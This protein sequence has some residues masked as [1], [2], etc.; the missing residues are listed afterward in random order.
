MFQFSCVFH[1]SFSLRGVQTWRVQQQYVK[2]WHMKG[3]AVR[4]TVKYGTGCTLNYHLVQ[5]MLQAIC[6]LK[7]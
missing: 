1:C 6:N 7:Y 4:L 5:Q 3:S 2:S